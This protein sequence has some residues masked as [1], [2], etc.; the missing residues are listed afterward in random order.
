LKNIGGNQKSENVCALMLLRQ[1]TMDTLT[2][3]VLLP[4][5]E[6]RP[7]LTDNSLVHAVISLVIG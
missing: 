5:F 3:L 4:H 6:L 7:A 2:A 1:K